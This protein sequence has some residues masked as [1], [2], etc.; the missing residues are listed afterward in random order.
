MLPDKAEPP[1]E[2]E[3]GPELA[4]DA[5]DKE[6]DDGVTDVGGRDASKAKED[7]GVLDVMG[8]LARSTIALPP[9]LPHHLIAIRCHAPVQQ[10]HHPS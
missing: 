10:P 5:R 2:V 9:T 7:D 3:G 8:S 6:V 1:E 4:G